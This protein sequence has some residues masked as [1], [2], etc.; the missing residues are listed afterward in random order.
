MKTTKEGTYEET[1][2]KYDQYERNQLAPINSLYFDKK[3]SET[4]D[5]IAFSAS[6]QVNV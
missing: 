5:I 4:T 6:K 1:K 2:D 3:L